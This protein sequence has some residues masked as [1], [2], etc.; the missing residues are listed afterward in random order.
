MNRHYRKIVE[1]SDVDQC[2]IGRCPELM[3]GGIHGD[4]EMKVYRELCEA[5]EEFV[6]LDESDHL[7]GGRKN[8][9]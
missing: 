2:F 9:S 6:K 1:W 7:R 5:I 4:D 3:S 8:F